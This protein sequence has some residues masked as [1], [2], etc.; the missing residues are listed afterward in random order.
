MASRE[1]RRWLWPACCA[2]ALCG[3]FVAG[4]LLDVKVL[5]GLILL[6]TLWT[7]AIAR[8]LVRPIRWRLQRDLAATIVQE[9]ELSAAEPVRIP[10]D[11]S[12]VEPAYGFECEGEHTV[13]VQG[14]YL[15]DA[16]TYGAPIES[17]N[18]EEVVDEEQS[19]NCLPA[20]FT[21]PSDRFTIHRFP[22]SGEVIRIDVQGA[23]VRAPNAAH[24]ELNAINDHDSVL[25]SCRLSG[26]QAAVDAMATRDKVEFEEACRRG[27]G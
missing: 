3:V 2:V 5:L 15:L 7:N 4:G 11:H 10:G 8:W 14:Q 23:S 13:V 20:P 24:A 6:W 26:L 27:A 1:G 17:T 16:P 25:L 9:L 19:A 21:W 18:E 22:N 12:S